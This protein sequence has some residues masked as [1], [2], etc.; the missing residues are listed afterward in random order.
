MS[1]IPRRLLSDAAAV[2]A[3]GALT[4]GGCSVADLAAEFGTPLFVYDEAHLRNRCRE[5]V[6]AFGQQRVIY[7]TKAF[8]CRAMAQLAYD[9]GL[10]LD[11][12]SG[13]ELHVALA[14]GVP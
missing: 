3:D 2:D 8:L 13:G 12:A 7:A 6:G 1:V 9:E 10:L 5:A 4:V 11:V 14:A